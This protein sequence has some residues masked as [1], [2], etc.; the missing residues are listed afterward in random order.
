M[1]SSRFELYG[2]RTVRFYVH[3]TPKACWKLEALFGALLCVCLLLLLSATMLSSK[4]PPPPP[5]SAPSFASLSAKSHAFSGA[6]L[7]P[8][9]AR[10]LT[11]AVCLA[12]AVALAEQQ[13]QQ[14]KAADQLGL[15]SVPSQTI[16]YTLWITE[17]WRVL[18]WAEPS[19]ALFWEMAT[20]YHT[21]YLAGRALAEQKAR[22]DVMT[23]PTSTPHHA[24]I[25]PPIL[26]C[27]SA[28]SVGSGS[29]EGSSSGHRLKKLA[30][31]SAKELPV[32]LVGTFLLL[33][34]EERAYQRN[35]SAQDERRF[36]QNSTTVEPVRPVNRSM[37]FTSLLQ[38][39]SLSPR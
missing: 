12:I 29:L 2:R 4:A 23:T 32:W 34:C 11:P 13:L 1:G 6:I 8:K 25:I 28:S 18:G 3:K 20:L 30:T 14:R 36:Y 21:L 39:P 37:N 38:H 9:H 27:G 5:Q 7:S 22:R 15:T 26:S 19:A 17:A 24:N 10:E 16:P 31:A 33:H 35:L